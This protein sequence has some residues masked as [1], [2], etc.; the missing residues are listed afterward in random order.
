MM[1]TVCAMLLSSALSLSSLN[2]CNGAVAVLY[3]EEF[4]VQTYN[5]I[6]RHNIELSASN[7][8]CIAEMKQRNRMIDLLISGQPRSGF[9]EGAV[10]LELITGREEYF[11]DSHGCVS[12]ETLRACLSPSQFEALKKQVNELMNTSESAKPG[13]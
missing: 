3:Y 9:G 8:I 10:R 5:A 11:V 4:D 13:A 2:S 1:T 7:R 12:G 6:T